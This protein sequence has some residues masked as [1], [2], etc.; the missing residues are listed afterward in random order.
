MKTYALVKN[1]IVVN[2]SIADQDWDSTGW[3]EYQSAGIGW[4][5]DGTGFYPPQCHGEAVLNNYQWTCTNPDHN[6][7]II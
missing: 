2:I 7:E 6:A 1:G 4:H 5:Y 3:V